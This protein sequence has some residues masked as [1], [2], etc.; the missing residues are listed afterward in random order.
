VPRLTGLFQRGGSY[1]L[2]IVLPLNHPLLGQYRNGRWVQTLGPCSHREAVIRGT[3]KRAEILGGYPHLAP[4]QF[5]LRFKVPTSGRGQSFV[6]S[7]PVLGF[8]FPL[9]E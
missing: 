3:I 6:P 8:V 1:Y 5:A 2:R 7:L 9:C 4:L